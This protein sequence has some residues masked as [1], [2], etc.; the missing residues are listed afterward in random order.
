MGNENVTFI[1]AV[2][3]PGI[4]KA[5]GEIIAVAYCVLRSGGK[6]LSKVVFTPKVHAVAVSS[7]IE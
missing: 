7:Y 2:L 6:L 4:V 5:T 1:T 3:S